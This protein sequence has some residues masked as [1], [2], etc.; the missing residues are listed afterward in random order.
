MIFGRICKLSELL[1]C[2]QVLNEFQENDIFS[3]KKINDA[4]IIVYRQ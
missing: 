2:F 3:E 4:L 1:K